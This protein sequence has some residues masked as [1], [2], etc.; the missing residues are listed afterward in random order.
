M[1]KKI[2]YIASGIAILIIGFWAYRVWG[3]SNQTFAFET[4]HVGKGTI[5][6]TVTATGELGAIT[7]VSVRT[8]V[9]GVI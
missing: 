3:S 2:I 7:T 5:S 6:N 8:Q 9:S 4:A 1:K